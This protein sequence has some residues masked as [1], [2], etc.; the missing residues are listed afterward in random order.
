MPPAH[1][2]ASKKKVLIAQTAP[3]VRVSIGEELGLEP[4]TACTGKMVAALR[5]LGF[6]YVFGE[7]RPPAPTNMP[8]PPVLMGSFPGGT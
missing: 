8:G 7:P 2:A 5:L 1:S 4:G 3:A 6:D